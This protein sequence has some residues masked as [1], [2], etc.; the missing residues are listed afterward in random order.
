[1]DVKY[2]VF[3]KRPTRTDFE[4]NKQERIKKEPVDPG[5]QYGQQQKQQLQQTI[6]GSIPAVSDKETS[7]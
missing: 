6:R 5:D 2:H 1:M 3:E 7:M 4:N